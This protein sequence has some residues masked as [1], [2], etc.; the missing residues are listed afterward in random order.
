M[1]TAL[2]RDLLVVLTTY[3]A[4]E[5]AY[6]IVARTRLNLLPAEPKR[7]ASFAL[8][9]GIAIM[10]WLSQIGMA[11]VVA[12]V[13]W[14]SWVE[15]LVAVGGAAIGLGQLLHGARDLRGR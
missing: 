1:E 12:P 14:R 3:G 10:A 6:W 11:Y 9:A 5:A 13:G 2:L 8:A 4:A 15:A 7:W